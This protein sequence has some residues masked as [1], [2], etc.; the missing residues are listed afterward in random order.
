MPAGALP[1]LVDSLESNNGSIYIDGLSSSGCC[2][3]WQDSSST[4]SD[5]DTVA[6]K[7]SMF[8]QDVLI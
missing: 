5:Y 2:A 7:C 8:D 6:S 4:D 1:H 3:V